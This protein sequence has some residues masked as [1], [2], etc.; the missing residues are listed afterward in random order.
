MLS[1][2]YLAANSLSIF[3]TQTNKE[4]T[5]LP[6][7]NLDIN[8]DVWLDVAKHPLIAQFIDSGRITV[9]KSAYE[10][11]TEVKV[12]NFTV[13][14]TEVKGVD[15]LVPVNKPATKSRK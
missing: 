12:E 3:R 10:V 1:I 11:K 15:E 7:L 6:G 14:A 8:E 5:L 2:S 4:F 9:T 13:E